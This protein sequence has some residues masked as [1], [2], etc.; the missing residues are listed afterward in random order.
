MAKPR[1]SVLYLFDPLHQSPSTPRRDSSPE[2]GNSDKENDLPPGDVTVFF[3]CIY[4]DSK[5]RPIQLQ[6]PQ[7]KLIDIGDTPVQ[8]HLWDET[9]HDGSDADEEQSENEPENSSVIFAPSRSPLVDLDL[10]ATPRP[11]QHAPRPLQAP[12]FSP[13]ASSFHKGRPIQALLAA[14]QGSPLAEVINSITFAALTTSEDA[15]TT[16]VPGSPHD[17]EDAIS[18]RPS[19]PFPVITVCAPETPSTPLFDLDRDGGSVEVSAVGASTLRPSSTLT[20][21]SSDDLRRVS[22]DLYSSFHLQMQS[23][24]MS[25]DLLNDKIS[26]LG[27]GQDSFW[28][29]GEDATFDLD[30]DNQA[31]ARSDVEEKPLPVVRVPLDWNEHALSP[32]NDAAQ[33]TEVVM[34]SSPDVVASRVPLPRS[35]PP[36][37]PP[38][39]NTPP[40]PLQHSRLAAPPSPPTTPVSLDEPSLLLESEPV[41][42]VVPALRVAKKTFTVM[43]RHRPGPAAVLGTGTSNAG[44]ATHRADNLASIDTRL[45]TLTLGAKAAP[46]VESQS[47]PPRPNYRGVQRPPAS[48]LAAG[49]I[50]GLPP[51]GSS[52]STSASTSSSSSTGSSTTR[53]L[54]PQDGSRPV[55]VGLQRP[56]LVSKGRTVPRGVPTTSMRSIKAPSN[57]GITRAASASAANPRTNPSTIGTSGLRPPS[58]IAAPGVGSTL[59]RPASKL[60]G[61][62][63]VSGL[64]RHASTGSGIATRPRAVTAP[65]APTGGRF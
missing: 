51:Q 31:P 20:Q 5:H 25:F 36:S 45:S 9:D 29:G 56:T 2:L 64:A 1:N 19:S 38:S 12:M 57:T 52:R 59:P 41:P 33:A 49:V 15:S 48:M 44:L 47:Q 46:V 30:E 42:P 39:R 8:G 28:A 60:P 14:P 62:S 63:S 61:P 4:A 13:G 23:A 53:A 6:T 24:E 11:P 26:F 35:P 10:E 17:A 32:P 55:A 22:V 37:T 43:G 18:A 34:T 21:L 54:R 7:G 27:G 16:A 65:R 3:D 40:L 58:R 50:I